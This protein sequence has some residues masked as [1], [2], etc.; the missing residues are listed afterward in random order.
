MKD[1]DYILNTL[2]DTF[3]KYVW[4]KGHPVDAKRMKYKIWRELYNSGNLK[5]KC[6]GTAVA[7]I[8]LVKCTGGVKGGSIHESGETK[9]TFFMYAKNNFQ[10]T[11]D[12]WIPKSFMKKKTN[13]DWR[14]TGNLVLMCRKCNEVKGDLVPFNWQTQYVRLAER[15]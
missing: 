13:L 2:L 1:F 3:E 11:L 9:Y 14:I 12:H 7:S 4:V 6:C 15:V 5:C 8:K 10:M